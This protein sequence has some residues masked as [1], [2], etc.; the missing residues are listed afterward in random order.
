[1]LTSNEE[2]GAGA[3]AGDAL[4][5]PIA[6]ARTAAVPLVTSTG[7]GGSAFVG[8][9]GIRAASL[10]ALPLGSKTTWATTERGGPLG[11]FEADGGGGGTQSAQVRHDKGWASGW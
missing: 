3:A 7:R 11:G 10:D 6:A 8:L 2:G 4:G 9:A 5:G 1:M